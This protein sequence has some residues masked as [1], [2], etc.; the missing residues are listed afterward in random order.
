VIANKLG[1]Q[2]AP[3]ASDTALQALPPS[4]KFGSTKAGPAPSKLIVVLTDNSHSSLNVRA[5]TTSQSFRV[6]EIDCSGSECDVV[7]GYVM[8]L[9]V[10][11]SAILRLIDQTGRFIEVP[12]LVGQ[13]K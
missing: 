4:L 13:S 7:V 11:Q 5:K 9:G 12:L 8:P 6:E 3:I 1:G 2:T 10:G